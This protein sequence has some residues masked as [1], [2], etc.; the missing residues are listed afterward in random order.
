[1][2]TCCSAEVASHE[3]MVKFCKERCQITCGCHSI[4]LHKEAGMKY[5]TKREFKWHRVFSAFNDDIVIPAG[6]PVVKGPAADGTPGYFWLS[7][8][9][10]SKEQPIERSDARTHGCRIDPDNV[11]KLEA[12]HES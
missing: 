3:E 10:F 8:E 1:M 2:I 6:A 11:E 7:E 4:E 12:G 9:F 5:R